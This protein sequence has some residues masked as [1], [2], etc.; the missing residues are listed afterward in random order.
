VNLL[1]TYF[2]T[3]KL[4]SDKGL[5]FTS[6]PLVLMMAEAMKSALG[7]RI[8][9]LKS[10]GDNSLYLTGF[11]P[12]SL[13]GK[14]MDVSYYMRMGESAYSH[15]HQTLETQASE[16]SREKIFQEL[17]KKFEDMAGVLSSI[18]DKSKSTHD[19]GLIHLYEKWLAT[20][21]QRASEILQEKG[22]STKEN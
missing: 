1:T 11:F 12:E 21:D 2:K 13:K 6:Q 8:E 16:N 22:I 7:K 20:K 3:E 18:S 17:A 10:I 15:L 5:D 4:L 14:V 9:L 19:K